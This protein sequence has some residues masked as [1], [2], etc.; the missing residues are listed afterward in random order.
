MATVDVVAPTNMAEG[1]EFNVDNGGQHMK[2][3]VP[4]GGA[5]A[6]QR[7]GA[8]VVEHTTVATAVPMGGAVHGAVHGAVYN[9]NPPASCEAIASMVCGIIGLLIFGIILGPIA[10]GLSI[11]AQQKMKNRPNEVGGKCQAQAGLIMGIIAVVVWVII[12][13]ALYA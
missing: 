1:Y 6:G 11:C 4:P 10:I 2:V 13:I 5:V 12:V 8:I 9:P 3:R 7:F